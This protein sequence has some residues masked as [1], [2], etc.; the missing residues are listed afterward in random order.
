[1]GL[2]RSS[3]ILPACLLALCTQLC[4]QAVQRPELREGDTWTYRIKEGVEGGS[5][6]FTEIQTVLLP[7]QQY[8]VWSYARTAERSGEQTTGTYNTS[9]DLNTYARPSP[10]VPWQGVRR[11]QWPLEPGKTWRYDLPIPGGTQTWEARVDAWEEIT[12]PAGKFK[13]LAISH[14]LV[15]NPDPIVGWQHKLWYS[16]DAKRIVKWQDRAWYE[17]TREFANNTR[18]LQSYQLH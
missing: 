17:G 7:L 3:S 8:F 9:K 18:E 10:D 11:W 15:R 13:T 4:A 6:Y 2:R 12:V 14:D 16:P 1:M 5:F